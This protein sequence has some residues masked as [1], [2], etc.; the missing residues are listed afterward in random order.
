MIG[1]IAKEDKHEYTREV[2]KLLAAQ[3]LLRS[4]TAA[5]KYLENEIKKEQKNRGEEKRISEWEETEGKGT[6]DEEVKKIREDA[7]QKYPQHN[8][9]LSAADIVYKW[10]KVM[11]GTYNNMDLA[12]LRRMLQTHNV[13]NNEINSIIKNLSKK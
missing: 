11:G 10:E 2:A 8:D 9:K 1:N 5:Y 3:S 12:R 7:L 6:F 13:N 4:G